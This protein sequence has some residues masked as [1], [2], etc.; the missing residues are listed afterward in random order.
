MEEWTSG[1][2]VH[3]S[4]SLYQTSL[5]HTTVSATSTLPPVPRMLETLF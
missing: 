5:L 4:F 2:G 3:S 1:G